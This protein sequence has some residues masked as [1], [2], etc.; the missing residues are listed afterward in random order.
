MGRATVVT[1]SA[2][3]NFCGSFRGSPSKQ[4][5]GYKVVGCSR[6]GNKVHG[7]AA[8]VIIYERWSGCAISTISNDGVGNV[9]GAFATRVTI[10]EVVDAAASGCSIA[11]EGGI[12]DGEGTGVKDATTVVT[13]SIAREGGIGECEGAVVLDGA[14]VTS[15]I[16][17]EGG[18]GDCEGTDAAI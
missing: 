18:I 7:A 5:L 17:R 9:E 10:A 6:R 15:S 2:K 16:A 4:S 14:A 11:R 3:V 1:K 8:R 12:G 13:S